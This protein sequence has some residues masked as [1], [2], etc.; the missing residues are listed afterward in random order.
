M[1]KERSAGNSS[2][3]FAVMVKAVT[4]CMSILHYHRFRFNAGTFKKVDVGLVIVAGTSMVPRQMQGLQG[5]ADEVRHPRCSLLL[6]LVGLLL[7]AGDPNPLFYQLRGHI[8]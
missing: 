5:A 3:D 6:W 4:I 1:G 2:T 7:T 8:V